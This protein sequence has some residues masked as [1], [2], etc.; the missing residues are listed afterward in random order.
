MVCRK[1]CHHQEVCFVLH[2][3][4]VAPFIK[5]LW[6]RTFHSCLWLRIETE[7]IFSAS[8]KLDM[9]RLCGDKLALRGGLCVFLVQR[10]DIRYFPAENSVAWPCWLAG[11]FLSCLAYQRNSHSSNRAIIV[12]HLGIFR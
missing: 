3:T 10:R 6:Q 8:Q 12:V 7:N 2:D 11:V 4:P 5:S 1:D 9:W